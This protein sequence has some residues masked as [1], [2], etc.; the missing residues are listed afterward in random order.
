L[1]SVPFDLAATLEN[2]RDIYLP[3]CRGKKIV[4]KTH[5]DI[6]D[7]FRWSAMSFGSRRFFLNLFSNAYKFTGENGEI[8]SKPAV[9]PSWRKRP[10][11]VSW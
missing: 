1:A 4:L 10:I 8:I 5:F 9:P 3:Q 7:A 6:P 2:L 11:T